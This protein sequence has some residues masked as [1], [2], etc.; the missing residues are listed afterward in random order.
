MNN[1]EGDEGPEHEDGGELQHVGEVADHQLPQLLPAGDLAR[2][3]LLEHCGHI[4]FQTYLTTLT[5]MLEHSI[6][7]R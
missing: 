4:S 5:G 1:V 3:E 6:F 2:V 7:C